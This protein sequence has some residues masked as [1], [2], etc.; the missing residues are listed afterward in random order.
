[1]LGFE[2]DNRELKFNITGPNGTEGY[3]KV[4]IAKSL[5]VDIQTV[6]VK[7]NNTEIDYVASSM[8]DSWLLYFTYSH[9]THNIIIKLPSAE[10]TTSP[11]PVLT[12]PDNLWLIIG[13]IILAS[14]TILGSVFVLRKRKRNPLTLSL[15]E[16]IHSQNQKSLC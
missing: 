14:L 13:A 7:L 3:V 10:P 1:V 15:Q 12:N 6:E 16:T 11:E 8:N 9:S 2:S 4:R 5:I